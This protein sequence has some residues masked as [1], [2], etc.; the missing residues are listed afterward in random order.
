MAVNESNPDMRD[1]S[2]TH[3]ARAK[4]YRITQAA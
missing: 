3:Q 1:T 2:R 4:V